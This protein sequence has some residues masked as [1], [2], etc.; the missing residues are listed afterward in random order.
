MAKSNL[1]IVIT[2]TDKASKTIDQV[3]GSL[4]NKLGKGVIGAAAIGLGAAAAG[5]GMVG[6]AAIKL[7]KMPLPYRAF[8]M[9]LRE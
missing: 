8:R 1:E 9:R 4:A 6:A 5:I 7:P 2:A 3:S